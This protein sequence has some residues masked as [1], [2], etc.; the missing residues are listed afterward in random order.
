MVRLILFFPVSFALRR[1]VQGEDFS[2]SFFSGRSFRGLLQT[3]D[4]TDGL[5]ICSGGA[6][7]FA[8]IHE[9][10]TAQECF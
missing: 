5:Q 9:E 7:S 2:S 4:F 8:A 10:G 6:A 3:P 1:E